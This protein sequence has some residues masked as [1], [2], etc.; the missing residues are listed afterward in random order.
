MNAWPFSHRPRILAIDDEVGFTRLLKLAVSQYDMRT[1]NDPLRAVDAAEEFQPDLILLD[2]FMPRMS[3][4]K[5]AESIKAHPKL[6]K[7][8]IAFV[9]GSVPRDSDGQLCTQ[10]NG[11]PILVKPISLAAIDQ[12]VK[13]CVHA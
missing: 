5:L 6:R 12:C 3:G 8:P 7:I 13:E 9:T 10:L 4:D 2:R 11:C 1:E